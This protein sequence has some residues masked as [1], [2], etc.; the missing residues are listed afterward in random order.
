MIALTLTG[1]SAFHPKPST[2]EVEQVL[3]SKG[4]SLGS[5]VKILDVKARET[6]IQPEGESCMFPIKSLLK[7]APVLNTR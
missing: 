4:C 5:I 2:G 1:C 6:G 3:N 7:Q